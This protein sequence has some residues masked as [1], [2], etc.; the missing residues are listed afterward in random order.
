MNSL[1]LDELDI[2]LVEPSRMQQKI[3]KGL[4]KQLSVEKI[5]LVDS[6]AEALQSMRQFNPDVVISTL[7]LP[8]GSGTDLVHAMK[9][10]TDL[11]HTA[12]VLISSETR[13]RYLDPVRQ[14]GAVAVLPKP[15]DADG[16]KT[17][18]D[19]TLEHLDPDMLNL[20]NMD[21]ESLEVLIV[22]DSALAR[23]HIRRVLNHMGLENF[24]EAKDGMEA[25]ELVQN[26]F[27]DLVVTDYN[28][29]R[30]DG[31]ELVDQIRH[32]S[33]QSSIPILMVT[34][35]ADESRLAAVQKAGVSAI[36]DKPFEP[37][38]VKA[39]LSRIMH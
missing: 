19:T 1:K 24:T 38:S 20:E 6:K 31:G 34:S 9:A 8:D 16:L 7:Y 22:D 28:M 25:L 27:F 17:A 26:R 37:G 13:F 35:E 14:A 30:M 32:A 39:L 18:L 2:L 10:D 3:I 36:C 21:P 23:K 15:F 5:R 12:F 29:P 33:S 11:E 4:L